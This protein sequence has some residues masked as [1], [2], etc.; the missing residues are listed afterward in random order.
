MGIAYLSIGILTETNLS[1]FILLGII[2]I[3][4]S[5]I[6]VICCFCINAVELQLLFSNFEVEITEK[7]V[8]RK[9]KQIVQKEEIDDIKFV[10][11][12]HRRKGTIYNLHITFK[13]GEIKKYFKYSP[14]FTSYEVEYFNDEVRRLLD[15]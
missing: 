4:I 2:N 1:P 10:Y 5:V 6:Y 11:Y 15:N 12:H 13:N 7:F 9:K 3:M 14:H 8:C